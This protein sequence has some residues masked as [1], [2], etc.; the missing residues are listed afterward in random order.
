MDHTDVI[1]EFDRIRGGILDLNIKYERFLTYVGRHTV[2]M[3]FSG[4]TPG[5]YHTN[6]KSIQ[7]LFPNLRVIIGTAKH[8]VVI[9]LKGPANGSIYRRG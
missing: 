4:M 5:S 6:L 8:S 1:A 3:T 7:N 2:R 9:Y